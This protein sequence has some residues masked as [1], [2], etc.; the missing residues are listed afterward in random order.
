MAAATSRNPPSG[1]SRAM[2]PRT[3]TSTPMPAMSS[4]A[5]DDEPELGAA[6]HVVAAARRGSQAAA[7]R[8]RIPAF[9][10]SGAFRQISVRQ[11]TLTTCGQP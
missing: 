8:C 2:P 3:L 5:D 4:T 1:A 6:P 9:S 10:P 7:T 11:A